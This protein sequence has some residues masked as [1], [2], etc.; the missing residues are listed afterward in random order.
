MQGFIIV[1]RSRFC[2]SCVRR[3]GQPATAREARS[4]TQP[5]HSEEPARRPD[6]ESSGLASV[7]RVGPGPAQLA[8]E[9]RR[10]PKS[11]APGGFVSSGR[12]LDLY[13]TDTPFFRN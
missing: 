2:E 3:D 4:H 9:H 1:P 11:K 6:L 12:K 8:L 7:K 10:A 5:L 13:P